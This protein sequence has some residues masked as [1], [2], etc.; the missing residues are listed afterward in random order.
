MV[1]EDGV[2]L[3]DHD[4]G[5]CSAAGAGC[6]EVTCVGVCSE[7]HVTG[8]L[9]DTIIRTGGVIVEE[10]VDGSIGCFSGIG[11][12]GGYFN[13]GNEE[14]VVDG[15]G[16]VEECINDLLGVEYSGFC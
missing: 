4:V 14:F 15:A 1:A 16:V 7:V 13:E 9:C 8:V 5:A 12:L 2:V 11:L 3:R 6:I 10:L